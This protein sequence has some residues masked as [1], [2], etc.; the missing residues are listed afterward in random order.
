MLT[1]KEK[2]VIKSQNNLVNN[3]IYDS[4]NLIPYAISQDKENHIIVLSANRHG[5]YQ[6]LTF[7]NAY[8]I[9]INTNTNKLS[10]Y[11][12]GNAGLTY[13]NK[14][15]EKASFNPTLTDIG[16][17]PAFNNLGIGRIPLQFT[18]NMVYDSGFKTLK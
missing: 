3:Y 8:M 7:L 10:L 13:L 15:S 12:V 9:G 17:H 14:N 16:I 4:V 18:E 1:D 11:K 6:G 2:S 5:F